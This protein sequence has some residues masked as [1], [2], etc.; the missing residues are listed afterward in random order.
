MRPARGNPAPLAGGGRASEALA[1]ST[2]ER[3]EDTP[4]TPNIQGGQQLD[5][6]KVRLDGGTQSR[7]AMDQTVV[8]DYAQALLDG[9]TFPPVVTFFDGEAYWLADGF[10]RHAAHVA[11]GLETIEADVREGTRRDAV[12]FAAGANAWHGLRRSNE[13]KQNAVLMLLRDAEWRK[14]SDREIGKRAAVDHK[15]VARVRAITGAAPTTE[16]LFKTKH[17]T[18]ATRRV[19]K[20]D[21]ALPIDPT[22]PFLRALADMERQAVH[23]EAAVAQQPGQVKPLREALKAAMRAIAKI[24][25]RL[26]MGGA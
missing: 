4:S 14:W 21:G 18:V 20:V 17:G 25:K 12:L 16:R 24:E 10:H 23:L 5:L 1:A 6:A 7:V 3:S 15:T 9:A 19:E 22:L 13:D 2:A 8:D 26:E 11:A